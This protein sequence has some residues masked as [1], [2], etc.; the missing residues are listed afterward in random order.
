LPSDL[1]G[2]YINGDASLP[3]CQCHED[4][5]CTDKNN[6]NAICSAVKEPYFNLIVRKLK[7]M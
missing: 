3:S 6:M 2:S 7:M 1:N 5:T 4:N